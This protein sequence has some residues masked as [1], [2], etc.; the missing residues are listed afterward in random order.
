MKSHS[1]AGKRLP[2]LFLALA[3]AAAVPSDAG[4]PAAPDVIPPADLA[5][6]PAPPKDAHPKIDSALWDMVQSRGAVPAAADEPVRIVVEMDPDGAPAGLKAD[7][8]RLFRGIEALGGEIECVFD[9]LNSGPCPRFPNRLL[10]PGR[11]VVR[12]RL[13][14]IPGR[15]NR[16]GRRRTERR[17][18][19][20][21]LP[22]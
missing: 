13:P 19:L 1:A 3:F 14:H 11:D 8:R 12:I 22:S 9:S 2:G 7:S 17:V 21:S 10:A 6:F 18:R 4:R 20:A 15:R 5:G 16:D